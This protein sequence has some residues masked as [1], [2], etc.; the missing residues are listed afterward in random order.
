MSHLSDL[1]GASAAPIEF[2]HANRTYRIT[3]ITQVVK[4]RIERWL[5]KLAYADLYASREDMP[6]DQYQD[7]LAAM[8][9]NRARFSYN[10]D[11]FWRT[12]Q[13]HEGAIG[14]TAILFDTTEEDARK[15]LEERQSDIDAL[16][17]ETIVSSLPR[18]Q[19]DQLRAQY[20]QRKAARQQVGGSPG[21][22]TP[23]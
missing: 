20:I 22:P 14:L 12:I 8:L 19:A 1:L 11:A 6:A 7:A 21:N 3:P 18:E 9:T 13:S 5:R 17:F 10:G 16:I 15:L 4:T 23:A 2:T